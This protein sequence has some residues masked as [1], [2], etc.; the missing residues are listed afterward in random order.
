MTLRDVAV[1]YGLGAAVLMAVALPFAIVAGLEL[2]HPGLGAGFLL[3]VSVV[4]CLWS[5]GNFTTA[6]R[7]AAGPPD[8]HPP[9]LEVPPDPAPDPDPDRDRDPSEVLPGRADVADHPDNDP[10]VRPHHLR[11]EW[12]LGDP[13]A[14]ADVD[15]GDH[16]HE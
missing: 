1:T 3:A 9:R 8:T 14:D 16:N 4:V 6:V 2:L 15:A 10:D 7:E 12:R 13:D 5:V 11:G